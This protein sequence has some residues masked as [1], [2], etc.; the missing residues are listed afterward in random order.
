MKCECTWQCLTHGRPSTNVR[1]WSP[2]PLVLCLSALGSS[3]SLTSGFLHLQLDVMLVSSP[4]SP[5]PLPQTHSPL[6]DCTR[7]P[8]NQVKCVP[9]REPHGSLGKKKKRFWCLLAA[10]SLQSCPTLCDPIDG[11]PPGSPVPGILQA[12]TL[13][14]VA[15]LM[16][17]YSILKRVIPQGEGGT[18]VES[19]F[20]SSFSKLQHHFLVLLQPCSPQLP[21][22]RRSSAKDQ[23]APRTACATLRMTWRS[24][25]KS[26]SRSRATLSVN[27]STWLCP[28]VRS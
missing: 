26:A 7:E 10:K 25:G 19:H 20:L 9:L 27:P 14:W 13:E 1:I 28:T 8:V 23:P 2:F 5:H 3:L 15:I 11:S 24:Q 16:S 18:A 21:V 4:F 17:S 22:L 6:T 12:R